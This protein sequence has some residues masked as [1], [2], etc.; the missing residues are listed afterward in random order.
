[1]KTDETFQCTVERLFSFSVEDGASQQAGMDYVGYVRLLLALTPLE[2]R[3]LRCMDMAEQTIRLG[4]NR[5]D[6]SI[7]SALP[8]ERWNVWDR[9]NL[10]LHGFLNRK[11]VKKDVFSREK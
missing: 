10:W 7:V 4:T 1:M 5:P 8:M 11:A 2:E 6:F 9:R 3:T